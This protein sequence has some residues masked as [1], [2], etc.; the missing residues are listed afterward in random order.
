MKKKIK[1]VNKINNK[2][3]EKEINIPNKLHFEIQKNNRSVVF[4][5]K[6]KYTRKKKH[7]KN[8]DEY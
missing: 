1:L 8:Y 5:D 3:I 6:T 4:K 2:T 7:K